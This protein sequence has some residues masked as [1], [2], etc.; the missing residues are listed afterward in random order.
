MTTSNPE[1][2][3]YGTP[4]SSSPSSVHTVTI[5]LRAHTGPLAGLATLN[6]LVTRSVQTAM[7]SSL[8]SLQALMTALLQNALTGID[9]SIQAAVQANIQQ[10]TPAPT[11]LPPAHAPSIPAT[12]SPATAS[13]SGTGRGGSSPS[14][15]MPH[16]ASQSILQATFLSPRN[17]P[18][19]VIAPSF[20]TTLPA[21]GT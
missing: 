11:P 3:T 16:P 5:T 8:Q 17:W 9:D 12:G 7:T 14:T 15:S 1:P 20:L 6:S 19:C 13:S 2:P 21:Y 18:H 4:R 10:L